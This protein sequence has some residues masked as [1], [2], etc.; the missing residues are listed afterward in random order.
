MEKIASERVDEE[1]PEILALA[2]ELTNDGIKTY[3]ALHIACAKSADCEYFITTDKRLLNVM[4][5]GMEIVNP[6]QFVLD[7]EESK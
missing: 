7:L 3:D 6:I 2:E 5:P 1:S 4:L